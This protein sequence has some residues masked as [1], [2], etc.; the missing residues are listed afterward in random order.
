MTLTYVSVEKECE[1]VVKFLFDNATIQV[2]SS[3]FI[4]TVVIAIVVIVAI[5]ILTT[6]L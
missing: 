6:L 4:T 2:P 5:T 1:D 3:T